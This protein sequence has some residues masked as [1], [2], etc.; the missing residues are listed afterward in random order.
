LPYRKGKRGCR[1]PATEACIFFLAFFTL[2]AAFKA[3]AGLL[4]LNAAAASAARRNSGRAPLPI[5][6]QSQPC[7]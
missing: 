5:T 7:R 2:S 4:R 3:P 6:R 1:H